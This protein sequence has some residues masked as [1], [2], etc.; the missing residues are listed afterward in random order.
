[1]TDIINLIEWRKQRDDERNIQLAIIFLQQARLAV[2]DG[3]S[4]AVVGGMLA[5]VRAK[6]MEDAVEGVTH[7]E[8]NS[9]LQARDVE[10]IPPLPSD[11]T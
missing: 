8:S 1:M 6:I 2:A 10:C 5:F 11:G 9:T 7:G 3:F 4:H